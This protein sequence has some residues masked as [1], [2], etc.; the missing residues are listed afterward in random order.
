MIELTEDISINP[1]QVASLRLDRR[2]YMNGSETDLEVRMAD[3]RHWRI[4]HGYGVDVFE[5]KDRIERA[6]Q[7]PKR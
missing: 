3:G 4:R 1:A 5:L 2:H 7:E 6:A